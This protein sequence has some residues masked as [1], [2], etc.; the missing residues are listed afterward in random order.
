VS[1][2]H[3]LT[4]DP[5]AEQLADLMDLVYAGGRAVVDAMPGVTCWVHPQF[6]QYPPEEQETLL[7]TADGHSSLIKEATQ[8]VLS[9]EHTPSWMASGTRYLESLQMRW[10]P[11]STDEP[12]DPDAVAALESVSD[13]LERHAQ[14]HLGDRAV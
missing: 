2:A 10:L 9:S 13:L 8:E 11:D 12:V 14:R 6:V 3:E 4:V 1:V 5:E 7:L